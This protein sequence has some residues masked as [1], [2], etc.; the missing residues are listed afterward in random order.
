M[1]KDLLKLNIN[2]FRLFISFISFI[3]IGVLILRRQSDLLYALLYIISGGFLLNGLTSLVKVFFVSKNVRDKENA[4]SL[5]GAIINLI[6]GIL[7]LNFDDIGISIVPVAFSSYAIIN[8]IIKGIV[9]YIYKKNLVRGY[10]FILIE[11]VI[12]LVFGVMVLFSPISHIDQVM[13]IIGSY[14]FIYS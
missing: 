10:L 14:C 1:R 2:S 7:L 13:I 4:I 3:S 5:G 9:Y 6:L 8:A 12:L 11:C